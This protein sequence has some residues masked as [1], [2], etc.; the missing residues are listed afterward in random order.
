MKKKTSQLMKSKSSGGSSK[1]KPGRQFRRLSAAIEEMKAIR[2]GERLPSRSW[3]IV[4]D[5]KGG[6]IRHETTGM[7]RSPE[8]S[9]TSLVR[10]ARDKLG[11]SQADFAALIGVDAGTLRGWEQGRREPNRAAR[12]LLTIATHEPEAVLKA[13]KVA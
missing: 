12:V 4:P 9:A 6:Y 3:K 13:A 2:R 1:T 10:E 11:L 5:G 8:K 7:R